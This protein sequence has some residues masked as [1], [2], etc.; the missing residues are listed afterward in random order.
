METMQTIVSKWN[1]L[2]ASSVRAL[3]S[4]G[5]LRVAARVTGALSDFSVFSILAYGTG[6][7]FSVRVREH[8]E[9]PLQV[10]YGDGSS[11]ENVSF[12]GASLKNY[13]KYGQKIQWFYTKFKDGVPKVLFLSYCT[14]RCEY[15]I[16]FQNVHVQSFLILINTTIFHHKTLLISFKN[17]KI[18]KSI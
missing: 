10:N 1:T 14:R 5:P 12:T 17:L 6:F 11:D 8:F 2:N 15:Y 16:I 3:T 9:I 7:N 18:Y 4:T 13:E